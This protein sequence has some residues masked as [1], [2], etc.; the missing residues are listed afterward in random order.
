VNLPKTTAW[1]ADSGRPTG[2]VGARPE[3]VR[4]DISKRVRP[5]EGWGPTACARRRIAT[6]RLE[7]DP[8]LPSGMI[9]PSL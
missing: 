5:L 8:R 2:A 4:V 9:H 6:P 7:H 1:V 3:G